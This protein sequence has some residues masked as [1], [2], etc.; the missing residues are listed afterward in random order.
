[1]DRLRRDV[2]LIRLIE[3]FDGGGVGV[4]RRTSKRRPIFCRKW[5]ASRWV[6]ISS[7]TNMDPSRSSCGTSC[8][9]CADGF[10][11]LRVQ[12]PAYGPS[13]VP[14]PQADVLR[15]RFPKTL[16]EHEDRIEFVAERLNRKPVV[17]LERLATAFY[18]LR[19]SGEE[20]EV[21]TIAQ[22]VH[23]MKPH[24]AADQAVPAV[25]TVLEWTAEADKFRPQS[26][27]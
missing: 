9:L 14:E 7:S 20:P 16:R 12:D 25:R 18:V 23:A 1:M 26:H 4:A 22:E 5:S 17:E 2:I 8:R 11:S 3:C 24:I 13:I 19:Q 6:L 10:V 27:A 21:N 15:R